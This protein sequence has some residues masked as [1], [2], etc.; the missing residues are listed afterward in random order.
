MV[1]ALQKSS[2]LKLLENCKGLL[3]WALHHTEDR[4]L[5][6]GVVVW[7]KKGPRDVPIKYTMCTFGWTPVQELKARRL[8][9]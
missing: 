6:E 9:L 2:L 4:V 7:S 1:K 8:F 5:K 3:Y